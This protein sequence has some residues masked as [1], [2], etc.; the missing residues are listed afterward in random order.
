[1]NKSFTLEEIRM[2]WS[3]YS[4]MRLLRMQVNGRWIMID[5]TWNSLNRFENGQFVT[6]PSRDTYFDMTVLLLSLTHKIMGYR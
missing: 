2:A 1:M 6:R 4:T 3:V 5:A